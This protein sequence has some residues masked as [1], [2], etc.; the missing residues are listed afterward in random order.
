MNESKKKDYFPRGRFL[1]DSILVTDI[2]LL[3]IYAVSTSFFMGFVMIG[4]AINFIQLLLWFAW[5]RRGLMITVTE[6][7]VTGPTPYLGRKTIPI[8]QIDKWKTESLSGLT[9]KKG[10]VD[11]WSLDGKCIR[12][13]RPILGRGQ[14][15][16]ILEN[17]LRGFGS[18]GDPNRKIIVPYPNE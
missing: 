7:T 4:S 16:F 15:Y 1:V 5:I 13:F 6:D 18:F 10:F 3:V 8:N 11:I 14:C 17:V 2:S 12:I 9:K